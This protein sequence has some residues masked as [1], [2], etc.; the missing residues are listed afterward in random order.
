M[1]SVPISPCPSPWPD[2]TAGNLETNLQSFV[3]D[4]EETSGVRRGPRQAGLDSA[5]PGPSQ[6]ERESGRTP[7]GWLNSG[8]D[9]ALVE[10][11]VD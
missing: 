6:S 3:E 2:F 11:R 10:H 9:Y 8:L 7:A 5:G 4:S 1:G